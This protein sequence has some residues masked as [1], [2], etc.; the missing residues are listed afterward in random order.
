[1]GP[2]YK[3]R[4]LLG[5]LRVG[6]WRK[7][8]L[9]QGVAAATE[10]VRV[11]GFLDGL[12]TI[13]DIGAN[14]GQ[15]ALTARHF[16]P[17][18]LILSFEPLPDPA[19]TYTRVFKGDERVSVRQVAIGPRSGEAVMYVSQKDDCSSLLPI[20]PEQERI[21]PGTG[22]AGTTKVAVATLSECLPE[23][24][25]H[26]PA[27]LKLDVQGFELDALRGCESLLGRFDWIYVECP[28]TE[29]YKGQSY[30]DQVIPW[31]RE[32]GFVLRGFYNAIYD[33][34][35]SAVQADFLFG[36]QG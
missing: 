15:F 27:L 3:L 12:R 13:V 34:A 17:E 6:A 22:G 5:I 11:L 9:R 1:V 23:S 18:S 21:F 33:S 2:L 10:H 7:A 28:F 36:R 24:T 8:L 26:A 19:R 14:R 25:L 30:A 35:G 4:K 31:L 16:F 32:R 29:L 20:S